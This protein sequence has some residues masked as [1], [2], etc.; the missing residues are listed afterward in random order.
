MK[1]ILELDQQ[2]YEYARMPLWQ[3]F[4]R[5]SQQSKFM[6]FKQIYWMISG[7][8]K[9]TRGIELSKN[10]KFGP[11]AYF[12]H[13]YLITINAGVIFGKNIN[14]HKGVTIGQ[15]NRGPRKGVPVIG[16]DVWIGINSTIVGKITI[17]NDVLIAPNSFVNKDIPSHSVV[18]GNPC[19]IY[20][21][22]NATQG[23]INHRI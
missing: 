13:A 7:I 8:L 22:K 12:G 1:S 18:I 3:F 16:D 4:L 21:R 6:L 20:P 15:E 5:K 10:V 11:G 9:R 17:G 23:Y 14:I 19:V 2:R